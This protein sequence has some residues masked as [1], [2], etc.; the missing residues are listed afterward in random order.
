MNLPAMNMTGIGRSLDF[1]LCTNRAIFILI[2]A[3]TGGGMGFQLIWGPDR[4]QA[5]L[6]GLGAAALG[7]GFFHLIRILKSP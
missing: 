7:A 6:W 2:L 4:I 1:D 3:V 5:V